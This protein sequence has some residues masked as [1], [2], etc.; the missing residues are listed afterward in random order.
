MARNIEQACAKTGSNHEWRVLLK[1]AQWRLL[2]EQPVRRP[3]G[4]VRRVVAVGWWTAVCYSWD[5]SAAIYTPG[6]LSFSHSVTPRQQP[7]DFPGLVHSNPVKCK[8]QHFTS[9]FVALGVHYCLGALTH[10]PHHLS[11]YWDF[12]RLN[13][14]NGF[15]S[16][17]R[18]WNLITCSSA[19]ILLYY[20]VVVCTV[21]ECS[22]HTWTVT[23]FKI[24]AR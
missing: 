16:I 17:I 12:K 2:N 21:V 15:Y 23:H 6:F 8:H 10:P 20:Y 11:C 4:N 13:V 1:I 24:Q 22:A 5:M 18:C 19:N 3:C 14:Y 7:V 9:L